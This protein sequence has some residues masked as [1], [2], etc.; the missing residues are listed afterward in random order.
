MIS[1]I[2]LSM[3][4][5]VSPTVETV[6]EKQIVYQQETN[7][8]LAGSQVDGESQLPPAFFVMKMN[9]PTASSLLEERLKFGLRD[10]NELG[11]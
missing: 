11:F 8:D 3:M 5:P 4:L 2:F 9:A 7:I 1:Y 6:V 10:Y